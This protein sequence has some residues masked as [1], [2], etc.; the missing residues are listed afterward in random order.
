ARNVAVTGSWLFLRTAAHRALTE[1]IEDHGENDNGDGG[2]DRGGDF[3]PPD[4]FVDGLSEAAGTDDA[5]DYHH[6]EGKH[7]ALVDAGHDAGHGKRQA[8]LVEHLQRTDTR[9]S[10]QLDVLYRR[11]AYAERRQAKGWWQGNDDGGDDRRCRP[12]AEQGDA[13]QQID[14][15]WQG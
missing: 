8:D 4:G 10:A 11:H 14:V 3:Q 1:A 2:V 7:Q 6:A 12:V 5:S 15:G 9:G 13:W